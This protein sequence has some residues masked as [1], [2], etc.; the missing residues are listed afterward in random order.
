MVKYR[1]KIQSGDVIG[2][3]KIIKP[4]P[5]APTVTNMKFYCECIECGEKVVRYSNRLESRHRGCTAPVEKREINGVVKQIVYVQP[6]TKPDGTIVGAEVA[7]TK[8]LTS[9]NDVPIINEDD[10]T[11]ENFVVPST[12]KLPKRLQEYFDVDIDAK[13]IEILDMA[14]DYDISRNFLFTTTFQRFLS[15]THLSRKLQHEIN[16]AETEMVVEGQRG[17][18]IAN[19]LLV[20]FKQVSSESNVTAR[21]LIDIIDKMKAKGVEDADPLMKAL[22]GG[23]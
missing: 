13:A 5:Y 2:L 18:Q 6:H 11:P 15:L 3:Y 8:T 14:S 12:V 16:K 9:V 21:L 7:T 23:K 1:G 22:R 19:P 20:Q 4:M 17:R 10:D